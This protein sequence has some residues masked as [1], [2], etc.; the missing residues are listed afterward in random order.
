MPGEDIFDPSGRPKSG[1][2]GAV[3]DNQDT[4]TGDS[5]RRFETSRKLLRDV[6]IKVAT[7]A[8]KFGNS[9]NQR[10]ELSAGDSIGF[11]MVDISTLYFKNASAG[12]NGTVNI[13]GTED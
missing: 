3:Y 2:S 6:V 8:Q 4:A 10:M 7:K 12:E 11:T 1:Y 5:A 13:L 9:S